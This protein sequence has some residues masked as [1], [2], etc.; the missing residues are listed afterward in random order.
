MMRKKNRYDYQHH[1]HYYYYYFSEAEK[2]EEWIDKCGDEDD[3]V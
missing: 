2:K 3:D 1:H